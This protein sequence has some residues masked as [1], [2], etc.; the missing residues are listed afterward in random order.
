VFTPNRRNVAS[1]YRQT[2]NP[3]GRAMRSGWNDQRHHHGSEP[4]HDSRCRFGSGIHG[5]NSGTSHR[6]A[7]VKTGVISRIMRELPSVLGFTRARSK[8][9]ATPSSGERNNS[10]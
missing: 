10:A 4:H 8:N 1:K 2:S 6:G 3:P 5:P 7:E 9:S